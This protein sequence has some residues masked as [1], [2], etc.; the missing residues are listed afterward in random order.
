MQMF[1]LRVIMKSRL[2]ILISRG[3][4]QRQHDREEDESMKQSEDD[5]EEEDPEE[6]RE[7]VRLAASQ[8]NE[9]NEGGEATIEDGHAHV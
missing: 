6:D 9:G 5:D 1:F 7:H 8:E 4:N 2:G 3:T